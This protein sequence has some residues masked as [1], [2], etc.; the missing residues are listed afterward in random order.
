M[1][2]AII[3]LLVSSTAFP[4]D[5]AILF[6]I[7]CSMCHQAGSGTRAPLPEVLRRM[8]RNSILTSLETGRMKPQAAGLSHDQLEAIAPTVPVPVP[9]SSELVPDSIPVVAVTLVPVTPPVRELVREL[10]PA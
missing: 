10:V 9:A 6:K 1:R 3:F 8:S 4:E 7:K 2:L 5:G